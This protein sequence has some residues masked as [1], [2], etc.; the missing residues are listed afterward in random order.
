MRFLRINK[1]RLSIVI[2]V[3]ISFVYQTYVNKCVRVCLYTCNLSVCI[4]AFPYIYVY[5]CNINH[6]CPPLPRETSCP[7]TF[8]FVAASPRPSG[9]PTRTK[10]PETRMNCRD[11]YIS[12]LCVALMVFSRAACRL[13]SWAEG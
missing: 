5:T 12:V 8:C 2:L 4:Y 11:V 10:R 6:S 13:E 7:L 9:A 1:F 3:S